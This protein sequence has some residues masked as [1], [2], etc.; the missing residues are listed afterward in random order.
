MKIQTFQTLFLIFLLRFS[1]IAFSQPDATLQAVGVIKGNLTDSLTGQPLEYVAITLKRENFTKA[2]NGTITDEKGSFRLE[3]LG[4]GDYK[5]TFSFVGY[6]TKTVPKIEITA[7]NAEYHSK[8]VRL[9]PTV[10]T[11]NEVVITTQKQLIEQRVDRLVYNV[12][13]DAG[14]STQS[15]NDILRKVPMLSVDAEG[16]PSLKGNTN[17]Q[18]LINGKPSGIFAAG[19]A[20]ALRTISADQ[21]LRVEV[22]TSASAKYDA[23]GTA[24]IINIITKKKQVEGYNGTANLA[25]G[26]LMGNNSINIAV[27]TNKLAINAALS[28]NALFPRVINNHLFRRD[29]AENFDH[30]LQQTGTANFNRLSS[31]AQVGFDYDFN[32]QNSL[33]TTFRW[34][35]TEAIVEGRMETIIRTMDKYTQTIDRFLR[36]MN[37]Q[38]K[39]KNFDWTTD[40]KRTFRNP[41]NELNASIQWSRFNNNSGY[42]IDET[43][44]PT[45]ERNI[46]EKGAT[47]GNTNEITGQV[48]FTNALAK[49]F[50]LETG[51]KNIYRH[52]YNVSDYMEYNSL[53]ADYIKNDNRSNDFIYQQNVSSVYAQTHFTVKKQLDCQIGSRLENTFIKNSNAQEQNNYWY[54]TP[55]VSAIY[56]FKNTA[57][58]R[59]SYNRRIQRPGL[60]Q[61]NPFINNVDP[62]NI[63]QGNMLL[64][65]EITDKFE[66][67]YSRYLT[68]GFFFWN[69]SYDLTDG[70]IERL[71]KISPQGVSLSTFQN[72]GVAKTFGSSIFTSLQLTPEWS[73]KNGINVS[74]Y[75]AKGNESTGNITNKGILFESYFMSSVNLKNGFSVE[76]LM[77]YNAPTYTIQ[78]KTQDMLIM[79]I[80]A[81]KTILK[82]KGA[83]SLTIMNPFTQDLIYSTALSGDDFEQTRTVTTPF[84]TINLGFNYKFGKTNKRLK[85]KKTINNS[86]LKKGEKDNF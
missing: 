23:E 56:T 70:L 50:T 62:R 42:F 67:N 41:K 75:I 29:K 9:K 80:T 43:K 6:E 8:N 53:R 4:I 46:Q 73:I 79:T 74:T 71:L 44:Y 63:S 24:G 54:L 66:L 65:P 13:K 14:A 16:T 17:V 15:L 81:K 38:K 69:I 57:N 60:A 45:E 28:S 7:T 64:K 59:F 32:S 35:Q 30:I 37:N 51:I 55:S 22:L 27:R 40:Y 10:S 18:I 84:R 78:G 26:H 68:N 12:E 2:I 77:N 39:D 58:V 3:G 61:L 1:Q 85:L 34:A 76:A 82:D 19:I 36:D 31:M 86:D 52:I 5:L 21:V 48:D 11:L 47:N 20:D 72:I 83:I 33:T 25:A 49:T